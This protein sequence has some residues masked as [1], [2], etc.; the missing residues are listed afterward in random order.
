MIHLPIIV[1]EK[2][3]EVNKIKDILFSQSKKKVLGF[4]LDE[5]GWFKGAKILLLK[6]IHNIGKDAVIIKNEGIIMSS[7]KMPEVQSILDDEFHPFHM[8]VIDDR[9]NKIGFIEDILFDVQNGKIHSL[10]ITEGVFDDL[11]HGRLKIPV[12]EEVAFEEKRIIVSAKYLRGIDKTGG[13]KKYFDKKDG[14]EG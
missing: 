5:G 6:D 2:G 11:I 9:G 10:E 4:L 1:L 8:E 13:I 12:S 14:K 7:T 3:N